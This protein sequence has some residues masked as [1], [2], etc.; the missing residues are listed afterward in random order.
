MRG[1]KHTVARLPG[2]QWTTF[3]TR[4]REILIE[5][6][7]IISLAVNEAIDCLFTDADE[8]ASVQQQA[9]GDL[10]RRPACL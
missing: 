6:K 1:W 5:A 8:A 10:L 2:A 7:P 9:P 3:A 4:F